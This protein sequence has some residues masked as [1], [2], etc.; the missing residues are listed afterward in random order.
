MEDAV[1]YSFLLS[2]LDCLFASYIKVLNSCMADESLEIR[3]QILEDLE[4]RRTLD[5]LLE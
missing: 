2:F 4:A 3:I 5:R 1:S